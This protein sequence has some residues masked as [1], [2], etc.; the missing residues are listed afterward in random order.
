MR[1]VWCRAATVRVA[2]LTV[3]LTV[4]LLAGPGAALAQVPADAAAGLEDAVGPM[5]E[6]AIDR[7]PASVTVSLH[8]GLP[9]YRSVGAGVALRADQFGLAV[10]GSWGSV[11]AAFG[12]QARWYPPLPA[13]IPLFLGL[14]IDAH[15]GGALP[16][17]VAGA[18]LPLGPNWRLDLEAGAARARLAGEP[19]WAPHLSLGIGF[20]FA[21]DLP[22]PGD[23]PAARPASAARDGT[24][25]PCVP[26]EP[27]PSLLAAAVDASVRAFVRDGVALY[28]NAYRDLR[29]RYW[30][31][32]Q[33]ADGDQATVRIRFEGSARAVL[34]GELVEASGTAEASYRWTGCRWR[35][36]S[37]RY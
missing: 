36:T 5:M 12:A 16:H 19:V 34:G 9:A 15:G 17:A 32:E 1:R 6:G 31:A 30:L 24:A 10:R 33:L 37:L 13:P 4:A 27:D 2:A 3:A 26:G 11:G 7:A 28:G 14:G 21:V 22:S 35:Q 8:G 25:A 29:Y 18:Q 23:G 20:A